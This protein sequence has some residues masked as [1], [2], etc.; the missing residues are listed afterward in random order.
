M[1]AQLEREERLCYT[2]HRVEE[3][4]SLLLFWVVKKGN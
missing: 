3:T 2:P 1:F 4:L